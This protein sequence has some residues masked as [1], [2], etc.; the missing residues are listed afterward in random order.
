MLRDES[1]LIGNDIYI[2]ITTVANQKI[3]R[4]TPLAVARPGG[5]LPIA[6]PKESTVK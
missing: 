2:G 1:D 5:W 3:N 4:I 6:N